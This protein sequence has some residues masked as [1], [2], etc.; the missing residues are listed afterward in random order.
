MLGDQYGEVLERQELTLAYRDGAF[1]VRYYDEW[2]PIAP[3]TFGRILTRALD[4]W[5]S[6]EAGGTD[7]AD[8]DELRSIVTAA[9]TCRRALRTL[10]PSHVATRAREKEIVKRRLAALVERSAPLRGHIERTLAWFNGVAGDPHSFDPLDALLGRAVVP[11]RVLARRRP[12]R[13]TTGA[14]ST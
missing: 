12:K 1:V 8:F 10:E 11:P 3:D 14:S 4:G 7:A 5:T 2:F 6:E 9:G 13:S